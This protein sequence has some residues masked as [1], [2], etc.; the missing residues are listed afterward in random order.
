VLPPSWLIPRGGGGA[1]HAARLGM[2]GEMK[3]CGFNVDVN[4]EDGGDPAILTPPPVAMTTAG[5]SPGPKWAL[6]RQSS[7]DVT[8]MINRFPASITLT[9]EGSRTLETVYAVIPTTLGHCAP[10]PPPSRP[11][12]AVRVT[13]ARKRDVRGGP[14][15]TPSRRSAIQRGG[16]RS[17]LRGGIAA[18]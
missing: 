7:L 4:V 15:G 10:C 5:P 9:S 11:R 14:A 8:A 1:A 13:A 17:R 18:G 16:G 6:R 3:R 12:T 2:S